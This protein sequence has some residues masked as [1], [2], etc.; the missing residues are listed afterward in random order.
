MSQ[1]DFEITRAD[2]N[3][4]ITVR[5]A[6]NAALQ[7][8]ASLSS[9]ETAPMITYPY[10]LWADATNGKLKIRNGAN[11]AWVVL[12]D[13]DEASLGISN[14]GFHCSATEPLEADVAEGHVWSDTA[15][16]LIKIR[17]K[18][19]D[20]WVTVWNTETGKLHTGIVPTGALEDASVT[21]DK[22][23]DDAVTR[24]KIAAEA[25]GADEVAPKSLSAAHIIGFVPV[26]ITNGSFEDVS[27]TEEQVPAGWTRTLYAG[28]SGNFDLATPAHGARAYKF[29]HPGGES[30][31]GGLLTSGFI[32]ISAAYEYALRFVTWAS[33]AGMKNIVRVTYY[34]ASQ[35]EI[36][37]EDLYSSTSNP[38]SATAYVVKMT[39]PAATCYIKVTIIGG[40]TDT[41]VIGIAYFDGVELVSRIKAEIL[42]E[43]EV[44][45]TLNIYADD[46][47]STAET[48]T[49]VMLKS[50]Y[51]P[52][53][54]GLRI[55]FDLQPSTSA[56]VYGQLKRLRNGV[57]TVVGT[58]QSHDYN[59]SWVTKSEDISGWLPGDHVELWGYA[60]IGG[61][62]VKVK[63]F[64]F[65]AEQ[66][67]EPIS[68][69]S[70]Y[71]P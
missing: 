69:Q 33:A 70:V 6:I 63:N 2:A 47:E 16:N 28:G 10:M 21:T 44:G 65:Y 55:K 12:G 23:E 58:L 8:L 37:S 68:V 38:T 15:N 40:Y 26:G 46:A 51:L 64:R 53:S 29:T 56:T 20:A 59:L 52:R 4:G 17:N 3:T 36:S 1:H 24:D 66:A 42:P 19:N 35:E 25:I 60:S 5:A 54:G 71:T 48:T 67:T 57:R 22:I 34:S 43:Y 30:N 62:T 50:A 14:A 7:A 11:T 41:D 9:G 27:E 45:D 32:E 18:D 61:L 39:V 13:L 49:G 31:G